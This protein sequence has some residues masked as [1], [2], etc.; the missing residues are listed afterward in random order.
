VN[1][2]GVVDWCDVDLIFAYTLGRIETLGCSSLMPDQ[3]N[4]DPNDTNPWRYKGGH[5]YYWDSETGTYYLQ[6]R[7]YDSRNGRFT[8]EDP[9]WHIGNMIY[10]DDP[11]KWNEREPC[12]F[13]PL[14]LRLYT[15]KPDIT[16]I[17]QSSNLYVYVMNNPIFWIDP[18]GLL[19]FPGQIHN[20]VVNVV[21]MHHGLNREQRIDFGFLSW[22]RADLVSATGQVWDVKRDRPN[23][24]ASGTTQVIRYTTGTWR[25]NP[26][27]SLSVGGA[28]AGGYEIGGQFITQIGF[29]TYHVTYRYA[30]GG[31]IAYDFDRTTNW[32]AVG[33]FALGA[34]FTLGAGALIILTKGAAAPVLVPALA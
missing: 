22:G 18:T 9:H 26:N 13:D 4:P 32:R 20:M 11:V 7:Y 8:Q 19:A 14:G 31:V 2:D 3:T 6:Q 30:G 25:N 29:N 16:A 33:E 10:G 15:L 28:T 34:A 21:A 12:Q 24:I 17:M 1:L 5:G 23:Q 27:I